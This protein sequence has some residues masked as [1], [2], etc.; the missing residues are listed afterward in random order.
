V[1]RKILA[2][3]L[4]A[5]LSLSIVPVLAVFA[6][7]PSPSTPPASGGASVSGSA[8]VAEAMKFLGYPYSYTGAS[9]ATGFSCIGFV[10]YVYHQ[11][12]VNMPGD[13]G[14]AMAAYPTVPESGLE[15]GDIIFFQNTWWAGVSH[16]GIYIGGGEIIHAENPQRG[17][18][19]SR[20]S[21]D[22]R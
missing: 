10:S 21:D 18:T 3:L 8:V 15:P 5:C 22:P 2:A 14:D 6:S 9:P 16:V 12:G 20:I 17:V 13:L 19:I 7:S 4:S 11:L 1:R